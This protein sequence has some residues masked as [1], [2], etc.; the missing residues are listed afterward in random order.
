MN[1][2]L[3]DGFFALLI[4]GLLAA[5]AGTFSRI[6]NPRLSIV[7]IQV[8]PSQGL[9]QTLL[10][11]VRVINPNG[12]AIRASGVYLEVG[13]NDVTVLDG[14]ARNL[15]AIGAYS[16]GEFQI[17]LSTNLLSGLRFVARMLE[18]PGQV[19]TYRLE[20]KIELSQPIGH[21]LTILEQ[22]EIAPRQPLSMPATGRSG[23]I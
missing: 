12:F 1:R 22:G 5:C 6:E 19:V 11:N 20:G 17:T 13:F 15:P 21:T 8:M 18:Q 4:A 14:V 3:I 23:S 10:L 16:E 7:D 2:R 9:E